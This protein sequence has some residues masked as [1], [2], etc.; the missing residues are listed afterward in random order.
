[1]NYWLLGSYVK[2]ISCCCLF[3]NQKPAKILSK[4]L[5][6]SI[7]RQKDEWVV[8]RDLNSKLISLGYETNNDRGLE[9]SLLDNNGLVL[10]SLEQTWRKFRTSY[11]FGILT[12]RICSPEISK[13]LNSLTVPEEYIDSDHFPVCANSETFKENIYQTLILKIILFSKC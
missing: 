8:M 12:L 9:D 2:V 13:V 7:A 4:E 3:K 11:H 10:N 1:M 5:F 6:H